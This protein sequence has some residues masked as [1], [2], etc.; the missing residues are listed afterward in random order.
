MLQ[1]IKRR[2]IDEEE[3]S[4]KESKLSEPCTSKQEKV[5]LIKNSPLQRQLLGYGFYTDWRRKLPAS[6]VHFL[7]GKS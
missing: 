5:L 3:D 6:T 2:R 7:R 4:E 1:Y